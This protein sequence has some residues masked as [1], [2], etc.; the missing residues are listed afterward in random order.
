MVVGAIEAVPA[1]P[2][3]ALI[4]STISAA[5]TASTSATFPVPATSS[6]SSPRAVRK[7]A[8]VLAV[9]RKRPAVPTVAD[10]DKR[11]AVTQLAEPGSKASARRKPAAEGCPP[12]RPLL[13]ERLAKG[14]AGRWD[15]AGLPQAAAQPRG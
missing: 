12:M 15:Q 7:A 9:K 2:A 10:L 1:L 8:E 4:R 14:A 6:V 11:H 5:V 3:A 13:V